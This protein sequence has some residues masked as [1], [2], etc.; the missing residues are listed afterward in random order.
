ME[1]KQTLE[2][3]KKRI[4]KDVFPIAR[5]PPHTKQ[6]IIDYANSKFCGD[7]GMC[8]AYVVETF[9]GMTPVGYTELQVQVDELR[10]ELELIK[11]TLIN[12]QGK[13]EKPKTMGQRIEQRGTEK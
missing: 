3:V 7:R 11:Q 1:Q 2:Q 5:I 8:I 10:I 4:N 12:Q 13:E 6:W 9:R